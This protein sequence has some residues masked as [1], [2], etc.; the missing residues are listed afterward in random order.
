MMKNFEQYEAYIRGKLM[1]LALPTALY[2]VGMTSEDTPFVLL[3]DEGF[4]WVGS[5]ER[6]QF[7]ADARFVDATTA[8]EYLVMTIKRPDLKPLLPDWTDYASHFGAEGAA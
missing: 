6:G 7:R 3:P 8:A 5:V 4:W 1:E 2:H